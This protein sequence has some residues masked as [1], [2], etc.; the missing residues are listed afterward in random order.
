MRDLT[1]QLIVDT[2]KWTAGLRTGASELT[3]FSKKTE[4]ELGKVGDQITKVGAALG[5]S[6]SAAAVGT[7]VRNSLAAADALGDAAAAAGI[8]VVEFQKLRHAMSFSGIGADEFAGSMSTAARQTG[9]LIQGQQRAVKAFDAIGISARTANGGIKTQEQI[10]QELIDRLGS[11]GS[12][13][14]RVAIASRI[15]G[16]SI[17]PKLVAFAEQGKGA[18]DELK[19]ATRT[20]SEE[21][22]RAASAIQD[23]WEALTSAMSTGVAS[24][25]LKVAAL[26]GLGRQIPEMLNLEELDR[27]ILERERSRQADVEDKAA[28]IPGQDQQIAETDAELERL[29]KLRSKL[30]RDRAA[31]SPE[32]QAAAALERDR[33]TREADAER[34]RKLKQKEDAAEAKRLGKEAAAELARGKKK[35][36]EE[37]YKAEEKA[38][39]AEYKLAEEL[40]LKQG[41][42]ELQIDKQRLE[43]QLEEKAKQKE[44]AADLAKSA[45]ATFADLAQNGEK[46]WDRLRQRALT[47]ITEL[48][49]RWAAS[50]LGAPMGG[51]AAGGGVNWTGALAGILQMSASQGFAAGGSPPVGRPVRV[52][53]SG[54]EWFVPRT[55]GTIVPNGR[56]GGGGPMVIQPHVELGID[57]SVEPGMSVTQQRRRDMDGQERVRLAVRNALAEDSDRN[58]GVGRTIAGEVGARRAP[59]RGIS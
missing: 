34:E 18:I 35:A 17:G 29:R 4:S 21:Q 44:L 31:Q 52:G 13:Q 58:G 39:L 30:E 24:I 36:V 42:L 5:V 14:E 33:I 1:S 40:A 43:R 49:I 55:A 7:L 54:E 59:R 25:A 11:Y 50:K 10:L 26:G 56:L 48:A 15:F 16:E 47:V 20:L 28:G 22:V 53:E 51:D 3:K 9:A 46:A 37:S 57:I 6:F 23:R 12:H 32:G 2:S 38:L 27:L 19:A 41:E 8:G 45:A